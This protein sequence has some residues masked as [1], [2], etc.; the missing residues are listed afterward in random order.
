MTRLASLLGRKP[1][2]AAHA[3]RKT[4]A[5]EVSLTGNRGALRSALRNGADTGRAYTVCS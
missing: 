1:L 4:A 2:V 5:P 3:K